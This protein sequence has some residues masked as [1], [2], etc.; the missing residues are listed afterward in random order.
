MPEKEQLAASIDRSA[1][2]ARVDL[3]VPTLID[4]TNRSSAFKK[5]ENV[6][7]T[8]TSSVKPIADAIN[9]SDSSS[10]GNFTAAN[11]VSVAATR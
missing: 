2:V 6:W 8:N 1:P 11:P 5:M 9:H 4:T 10:D 7:Y 3:S